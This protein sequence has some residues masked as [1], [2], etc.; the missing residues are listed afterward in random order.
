MQSS[1][2][3]TNSSP[4]LWFDIKPEQQLSQSNP[5]DFIDESEDYD[6]ECPNCGDSLFQHTQ[7]QR[8]KCALERIGGIPKG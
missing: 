3:F 5:S 1:S 8:I 6:D 7:E 4:E 2:F